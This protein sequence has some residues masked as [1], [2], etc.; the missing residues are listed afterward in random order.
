[1]RALT[2]KPHWAYAVAHMGKRIENRSRPIPEALIGH[3]VAIHAGAT[4]PKGWRDDLC[5]HASFA[6]VL[7][8]EPLARHIVA[9]AVLESCEAPW[10]DWSPLWSHADAGSWWHLADVRTLANPI[11][12][13]RGQLGLWHLP[14]DISKQ[15]ESAA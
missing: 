11:P 9:T 10:L 5:R 4:L 2:L 1:M 12:M 6:Q 13:Q 14:E 7:E 3:R 15:L 8:A